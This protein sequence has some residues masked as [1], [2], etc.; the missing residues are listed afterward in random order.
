VTLVIYRVDSRR[1]VVSLGSTVALYE[2]F[3]MFTEIA[4]HRRNNKY[5]VVS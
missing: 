4:V 2:L 3:V 1:A 5:L